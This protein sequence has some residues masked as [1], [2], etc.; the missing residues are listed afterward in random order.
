MTI[1]RLSVLA[2]LV[3]GSAGT[4][5]SGDDVP[6][7]IERKDPRFDRIVPKDA[8][9]ET[10]ADGYHWTE[11]PVWDRSQKAILFSDI[12]AN[13]VFRWTEGGPVELFLKPSGYLGE[14]P[15][16]GREPGSNGLTFD[17]QGRLVLCQHGERRVARLEKDG[18]F[19]SLADHYQGKRFNSPNDLVF[20]S[21][22]DLYFTDP[23]YGLPKTFDDPARELSWCGVYRLTPKGDVV[24]LTKDVKAPN[25]I[26]FS[27]DEKT[28]YVT[29][30]DP[31]K[32]VVM[33]YELAADGSFKGTRIFVDMTTWKAK[34]PGGPDG[35]KVDVT[36]N[37][38]TTGPGGIHVFASDGTL[39]G[40]FLT[41]VPTA[42]LNWG[43]DGSTLYI[44][45]NTALCRVKLTTRGKGF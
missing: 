18:H 19:K 17:N 32:A 41:G 4:L 12:P 40:S 24:L 13:A 34:G 42:N 36:G 7:T 6:R 23:P 16:E 37:V 43:G 29:S 14:K 30:S 44:T 1:S 21:N 35:I 11:G 26:A 28:L 5:R 22:G 38:F 27:P 31:E 15:F 25:G 20:R 39:L 2:A 3:L 9:L 10:L 33:A 45:A 8:V